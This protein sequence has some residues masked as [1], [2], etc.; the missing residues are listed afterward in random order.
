VKRGETYQEPHPPQL[1]DHH[2]HPIFITLYQEVRLYPSERPSESERRD[3][4]V[5]GGEGER[6]DLGGCRIDM[7]LILAVV[8][9]P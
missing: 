1:G 5:G 2:K 9:E 6:L 4:E 7:D 3:R 8:G